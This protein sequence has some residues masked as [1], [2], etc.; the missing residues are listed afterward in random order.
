MIEIRISKNLKAS[1]KA[2]VPV[3]GGVSRDEFELLAQKV[4]EKQDAISDLEDIR[5]GAEKGVTAVQRGGLSLVAISGNYKDLTNRPTIPSAVTESTVSGW[6][7]TKNAGTYIKPNGGIP[8]S[9]LAK[10]VLSKIN[11]DCV[12]RN[13]YKSLSDKINSEIGRATQ[14][15]AALQKQIDELPTSGGDVDLSG[16]VQNA[17]FNYALTNLNKIKP[18]F[19]VINPDGSVLPSNA[20]RANIMLSDGFRLVVND[21]YLIGRVVLLE[22]GEAVD[23][24]S[25][26][27]NLA[28]LTIDSGTQLTWLLDIYKKDNTEF[29]AAELD[30]VIKSLTFDTIRWDKDSNL[31][32]YQGNGEYYIQ[33]TRTRTA[34]DNMPILNEGDVEGTLK[35]IADSVSKTAVQ[36]LTLL[37]VGGGDGNIYT[38]TR[39]DNTWGQW[40]KLQTNVEVGVINQQQ[41]DALVD[42]GI[43]SGV[44][45]TT[46]ETFVIICINNYAIATQAGYGGYISQLKY[47]VDLAGV[48][49]VE[50]RRRDAFGSWTEWQSIGGSKPSELLVPSEWQGKLSTLSDGVYEFYGDCSFGKSGTMW[51]WADSCRYNTGE[52]TYIKL[53]KKGQDTALAQAI[54]TAASATKM[55]NIQTETLL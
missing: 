13:E 23:V 29:S 43:Y 9:D 28:E 47:S 46:G 51:G 3:R 19:G 4:K 50:T 44:L 20:I 45:S 10:D 1:F 41:M 26:K 12:S 33:G 48:V 21:G 22:N 49:K 15:E 16:Y 38:R 18:R 30:T 17:V 8:E 42:N 52:P 6:G 54:G 11:K 53:I 5:K 31:N 25:D 7:F 34:N 55:I 27:L 32:D 35:V 14:A 37:N 36:I 2:V 24:W 39:Q 40:G